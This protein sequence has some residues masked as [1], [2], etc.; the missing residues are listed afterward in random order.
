MDTFMQDVRYALRGMRR[1]PGFT[2]AAV[3]TLALGMGATTAI[4]SVIRAVLLAPLPYAQPERRVMIWSRW[5]DFDKTWVADGEV[6]DYRRL[7]P[8]LESVAAWESDEAN[9]TGGGAEP[10]PGRHRGRHGQHLRHA[11]VPAPDRPRLHRRRGSSGRPA[12]RGARIRPLEESPR[13]RP[14]VVGS[15]IELDGVA[16]RVVGV[17][18]RGFALPTDFTV[19][20][21]EP[22]QVWIPVQFDPKE[23]SHGNH[24]YYA[25][26]SLRRG[27]D[28]GS[29]HGRAAGSRREPDA[30]GRLSGGDALRAL[31]RPGRGGDPRARRGARSVSCSARSSFFC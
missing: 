8:S 23:L 7:V 3:L 1:S 20:A 10:A 19:D 16:R 6:M 15:T 12:R 31:R 29:R 4:F 9:L 5:K 11:R 28:R 13:R 30:P 18:P 25:A 24:G 27:R 14:E 17:M 2:A 26:G 21:S 22:S